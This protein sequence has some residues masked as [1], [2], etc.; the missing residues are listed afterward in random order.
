[1]TNFPPNNAGASNNPYSSF[2]NTGMGGLGGRGGDFEPP[3]V[4]RTSILAVTALVLSL[5]CFIPGLGI[6]ALVLG[7]AAVLLISR[8]RGRLSGLGLAVTGCVIGLVV[9]VVWLLMAFGAYGAM[10]SGNVV[11]AKMLTPAKASLAAIELGDFAGARQNFSPTLAAAVTDAQLTDFAAGYRAELGNY[12]SSPQS[13]MDYIRG[14]IVLS[15]QMSKSQQQIQQRQMQNAFPIPAEFDKGWGLL[16]VEMPQNFNPG[17][18]FPNPQTPGQPSPTTMG[19]MPI[20]NLG[21]MTAT[22]KEFW[23]IPKLATPSLPPVAPAAPSSPSAEPTDDR[24][25]PDANPEPDADPKPAGGAG[26]GSGPK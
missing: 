10:Q 23:L 20:E 5:I 8:S 4:S 9:T 21:I 16:V 11:M 22:G 18:T 1:M 17:T 14:W 25:S 26:S 13:L 6:I 7:G 15:E 3:V 24:A 19:N 12:K 2:G